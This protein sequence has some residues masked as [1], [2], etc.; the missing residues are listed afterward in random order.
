M[1]QAPVDIRILP[2][3]LPVPAARKGDRAA[4]QADLAR[5]RRQAVLVARHAVDGLIGPGPRVASAGH[6]GALERVS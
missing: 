4:F 5:R 1:R 3:S 6:D 2:S